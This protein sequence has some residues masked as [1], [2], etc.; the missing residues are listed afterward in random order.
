VPNKNILLVEGPDDFHV[1]N[2]LFVYH[3]LPDKSF[4]IKPQ[5]GIENL[6]TV[7]EAAI[8][9]GSSSNILGV[10]VDAD[11]SPSDRWQAIKNR[12]VRNNYQNVPASLDPAGT[13]ITQVG[14]PTVGI[15]VM[16]DNTS[17][18]MLENFV[19]K[20]VPDPENNSLW[21]LAEN[22]TQEAIKISTEIPEAKAHIH[23]Y[24]AWQ[25]E[26][27]TPLGL[28]ITKQYFDANAPAA[29][30]FIDWVRR[31]YGLP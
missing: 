18:G 11:V 25:K 16:P 21:K 26:P 20:F 24:L 22:C 12:L 31:L 29:Q 1:L 23:T 3:Q 27:G 19:S 13:I 6:L 14:K 15:W 7:L 4:E 5:T 8:A 9:G 28:A 10:M 17:P 30:Q 2:S